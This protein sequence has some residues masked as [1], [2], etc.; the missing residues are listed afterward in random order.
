MDGTVVTRKSSRLLKLNNLKI[1]TPTSKEVSNSEISFASPI[2]KN[3]GN[4][5]D[6]LNFLSPTTVTK[7][8]TDQKNRNVKESS[9]E[10]S[11]E[12]DYS[13][14]SKSK[15]INSPIIIKYETKRKLYEQEIEIDEDINFPILNNKRI[16]IDKT[17]Y[18]NKDTECD[19]DDI[20]DIECIKLQ[21]ERQMIE[22][23]LYD[24]N[25]TVEEKVMIRI[26]L[27]KSWAN[28]KEDE[29]DIESE[30]YQYLS[31]K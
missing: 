6:S 17:I 11:L 24:D 1:L 14:I 20:N 10:R 9:I 29:E 15:V 16:K 25:I 13:E 2:K 30:Y 12:G 4:N 27:G 8:S 5:N 22:T 23:L 7:V 26:K 19:Y 21:K 28:L 31:L 18:N 3:K